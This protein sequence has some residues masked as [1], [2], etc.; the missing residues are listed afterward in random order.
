MNFTNRINFHAMLD[1]VYQTTEAIEVSGYTLY[2]CWGKKKK[3]K[4]KK[5]TWKDKGYHRPEDADSKW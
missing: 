4:S 5:N 3:G 1:L 2:H